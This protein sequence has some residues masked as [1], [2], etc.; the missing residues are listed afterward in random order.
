MAKTIATLLGVV[1]ILVGIVGF[2]SH[3]FLGTHLNTAHNLV[4][5]ISGAI[6][7]YFGLAGSLPGARTFCIV[8]GVV[9]ALLGVCGFV[10][11]DS[12]HDWLLKLDDLLM[13]GKMDHIVHILLGVVFLIGGLATRAV[14]V[15]ARD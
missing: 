10:L 1:F 9:Y 13:L 11:G 12:A 15:N 8:F 5:L 2:V 3:D 6:S 4:H 7:L 14:A